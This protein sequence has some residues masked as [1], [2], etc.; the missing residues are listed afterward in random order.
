MLPIGAGETLGTGVVVL[1]ET[2][3]FNPLG[4]PS[5]WSDILL[6]STDGLN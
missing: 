5:E 6:F 2:S 1:T 4:D 3:T